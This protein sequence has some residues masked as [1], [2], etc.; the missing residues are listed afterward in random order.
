MRFG[1]A[2]WYDR[3]MTTLRSLFMVLVLG[4]LLGGAQTARADMCFGGGGDD[5]VAPD[6]APPDSG[7]PDARTVDAQ[8][9]RTGSRSG[10]TRQLAGGL[11]IVAGLGTIWLVNRRRG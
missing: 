1:R 6:A 9:S 5:D 4:G 7:G 8:A 10:R 2:S 11:I 3:P